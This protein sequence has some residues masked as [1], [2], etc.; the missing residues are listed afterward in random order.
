MYDLS[1]SLFGIFHTA[2]TKIEILNREE[3]NHYCNPNESVRIPIFQE[4]FDISPNRGY[5]FVKIA[6]IVGNSVEYRKTDNW[7]SATCVTQHTPMK[8]NFWHFS[9]TWFLS[10][11]GCNWKDLNNPSNSWTKRFAHETVVML[12]EHATI[13]APE[14]TN[15][16]ADC[17]IK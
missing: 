17:Y 3:Y 2:H 7:Y 9:I 5:W 8:W 11:E 4:D 16:D 6:D 13:V 12:R 10:S 14:A 1:C 15:I